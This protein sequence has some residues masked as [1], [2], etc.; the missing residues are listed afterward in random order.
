MLGLAL[1]PQ[2]TNLNGALPLFLLCRNRWEGY[3]LAGLS[4]AVAFGQ[5]L[6]APLGPE[7]VAVELAARWPVIFAGLWLP[8]LGL[9]LLAERGATRTGS[10]DRGLSQST[11]P[12]ALG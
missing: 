11:Q 7:T 5:H 4:F 2:T 8:A 12:I 10:G 6:V 1:V 9:V 3:L